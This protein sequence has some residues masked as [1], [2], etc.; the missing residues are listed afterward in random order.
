MPLSLEDTRRLVAGHIDC[1][2][3]VRLHRALGYVTP[4]GK[5]EGKKKEISAEQDR[6]LEA[7]RELRRERR[8]Q[9]REGVGQMHHTRSGALVN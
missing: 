4:K 5:L 6:K 2:N 7:A 8:Q 1:Y 9:A 3:Q